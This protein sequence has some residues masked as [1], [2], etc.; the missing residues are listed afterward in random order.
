[1]A[2]FLLIIPSGAVDDDEEQ[3]EDEGPV[4]NDEEDDGINERHSSKNIIYARMGRRSA[5]L[6]C[7]M[8][9]SR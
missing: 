6:T 9:L 8:L 4:N 2:G 5:L 3:E 1:M 7:A